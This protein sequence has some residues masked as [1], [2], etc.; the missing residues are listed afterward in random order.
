MLLPGTGARRIGKSSVAPLGYAGL[1]RT[2]NASS[3]SRN[4][5]LLLGS[6]ALLQRVAAES[7]EPG[8]TCRNICTDRDRWVS[9][10][11]VRRLSTSRPDQL[12]LKPGPAL[13]E[14]LWDVDVAVHD[15]A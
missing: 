8:R 5:V 9:P 1:P 3:A 10:W 12:A 15:P 6:E 7:P 14:A 11:R 4:D 13:E 2:I